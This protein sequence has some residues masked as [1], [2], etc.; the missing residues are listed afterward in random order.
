M[1]TLILLFIL[2]TIA[3]MVIFKADFDNA[4]G[5]ALFTTIMSG[6]ILIALVEG[7]P[8]TIRTETTQLYSIKTFD[9][10][11]GYWYIGT[12]SDY[13]SYIK[14]NGGYTKFRMP[15]SS[16]IY[17]D[18]SLTN[19]GY[20]EREVCV[21]G[22]GASMDWIFTT[23]PNRYCSDDSRNR[24]RY[25]DRIIRVPKNTVTLNFKI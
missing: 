24:I 3:Y 7:E 25:G 4:A 6:L 15:E 12:D 5:G 17:E 2:S 14:K 8:D 21:P 20:Y 23:S 10:V 22:T 11:N 16:I 13:I 9:N 1:F 18:D 19:V